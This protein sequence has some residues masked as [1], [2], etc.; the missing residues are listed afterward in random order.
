MAKRILIV[1]D[2]PDFRVSTTQI[3]EKEGF[4][5]S[6]TPRGSEGFEKAKTEKPDAILL[7]VMIENSSAGLD[8]ARKLRDNADTVGIPVILLTGIRR[9]D[10]LLSSYAPGEKWPNIKEALEKPV[11]PGVLIAKLKENI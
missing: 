1:D 4:E 3:L 9:A 2:D 5:V 7:D 6:A 11:E 10:Q 8:T